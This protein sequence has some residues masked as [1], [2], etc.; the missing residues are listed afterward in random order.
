M[1]TEGLHRAP[2]PVDSARHRAMA[3]RVPVADW[4]IAS[5]L[6]GV[7]VAAA[8]FAELCLDYAIVFVR[9]AGAASAAE[10]VPIA[11]LGLARERNLYLDGPRWRVAPKPA[12]LRLY[13]FCFGHDAAGRAAVFVD[14]GWEG[15]ADAGGDDGQPPAQRLF[16]PDGSPAPLLAEA[17]ERLQ[18][19]A[20]ELERTRAVGRRLVELELLREMRYDATLPDG[21][22]LAVEAFLTVDEGRLQSLPDAVV[23][24]LHRSGVLGL[25]HAHRLSLRNL[26]RLLEWEA[27]SGAVSA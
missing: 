17:Q 24:E 6:N 13:P 18:A 23:L 22:R 8:E 25:L 4:R 14:G 9:A 5:R 20:A 15:V 7:V 16:A 21:R 3:L 19:F 1:I 11:V 12:V 26:R 27:Q 2:V 10:V